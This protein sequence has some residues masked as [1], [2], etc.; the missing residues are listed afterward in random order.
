MVKLV[1]AGLAL[2]VG[3]GMLAGGR[4]RALATLRLRG[5]ALTYAAAALVALAFVVGGTAGRGLQAAGGLAVLVFLAANVRPAT[6]TLR[7]ALLTIAVGWALNGAVVAANGAMPL[8]LDAYAASGQTAP[9]TP[10]RG[11][12]FAITL[13]DEGTVLAPL[14][15][16]VPLAPLRVVA[17]PGDLVLVAGLALAIVAGMRVRGREHGAP[18]LLTTA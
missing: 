11:G 10:G 18:Q 13:A 15:D 14:G 4:L 9:P 17:S 12:F 3:A 7:V 1:A 8:S 16:V 2:G 6:G 5:L